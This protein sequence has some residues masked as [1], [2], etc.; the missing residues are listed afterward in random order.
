MMRDCP[1]EG[2]DYLFLSSARVR[3]M[4]GKG[5][6]LPPVFARPEVAEI[7]SAYYQGIDAKT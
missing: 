7:L 1:H 2:G 6:A 5:E 3:E 4:L